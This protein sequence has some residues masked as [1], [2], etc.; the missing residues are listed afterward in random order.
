MSHAELTAILKVSPSSR[1]NSVFALVLISGPCVSSI[2]PI[3]KVFCSLIFFILFITV[4]FQFASPCDMFILAIFMP[5]EA[6]FLIISSLSVL[7]PIVAIIFV[8]LIREREAIVFFKGF[9]QVK[10]LHRKI[11][12]KFVITVLYSLF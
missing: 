9:L 12:E 2:K 10:R 4:S 1:P 7:G 3:G 5:A 6:R 8:L 11:I